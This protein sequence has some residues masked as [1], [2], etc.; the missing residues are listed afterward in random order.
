MASDDGKQAGPSRDGPVHVDLPHHRTALI[1]REIELAAVTALLNRPDVPLVTLTGPGG[2]GKTRLALQVATIAGPRFTDGS[3]VVPLAAI[4]DPPLVLPTIGKALGIHEGTGASLAHRIGALHAGRQALLVLDN[5]EQV[6]D[7]APDVAALLA[8]CPGLTVLV[9]SRAPLRVAGE[10]EYP[11]S[12]LDLPDPDRSS[13]ERLANAGAVRLFMERARAVQPAFTLTAENAPVVADICCRLD[14]LPLAIE[15]AAARVKVLPLAALRDRLEHRLPFLTGGG[16]DWPERHQT[17]ETSIAWSYDLLAPEEQRFLRQVS[18]FVGGFTLEAAEAVAAP[19]QKAS[20][21]DLVTVLVDQSLLRLMETLG[22]SPRYVMLETIREFAEA[23]LD[24]S[25]EADA[26]RDRHV[27]WC[28]DFATRARADLDPV[29]RPSAVE[30][31]E[32][33]HANLRAAL[34]WL[35]SKGHV[36]RLCTLAD[37]LGMF[38]LLGGH[39]IEGLAWLRHALVAGGDLPDAVRA[40]VLVDAGRQAV[41]VQDA[42]APTYLE[43]GLALAKALGHQELEAHATLMLGILAQDRGDL[44]EAEALLLAARHGSDRSGNRNLGLYTDYNLGVVAMGQGDFE[45][46]RTLLERALAGSREIGDMGLPVWCTAYLAL[47][48]TDQHDV[49][50][51]VDLIQVVRE[52]QDVSGPIRHN[53][54]D[55]LVPGIALATMLGE[56][57]TAAVLLGAAAV[58]TFDQELGVP[59]KAYFMRFENAARKK[60]GSEAF[61]AAWETGRRMSWDQLRAAMDRLVTIAE[62]PKT[63]SLAGSG[64]SSLTPREQEILDLVAQGMTDREIATALFLSTRTVNVHVGTI[65]SKLGVP[66]RRDAAR[67]LRDLEIG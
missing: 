22:S 54:W 4:R 29:I 61:R 42:A 36:T 26:V 44:E 57:E 63:P 24:A 31:I 46:A 15:L 53:R 43:E 55:S 33:E 40:T 2:V 56:S 7:A 38:W 32:V 23:N 51:V 50:R 52:V 8:T 58:A 16:R 6:L 21:L 45:Q 17:M 59:E 65:L 47:I 3:V 1:G 67:I 64:P 5:V 39:S 18:V 19:D 12:A 28:Q 25:G 30:R 13:V 66:S 20:A 41:N 14:G 35:A 34:G 9:T 10:H 49:R 37:A 27:A 11:V 48:A 60:L 62:R